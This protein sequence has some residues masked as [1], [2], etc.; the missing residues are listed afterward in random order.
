MCDPQLR[1][2]LDA[3]HGDAER[4]W[5]VDDLAA[6]AAMSRSAFAQRF[7]GV[8]GQSPLGYLAEWRMQ[9][10]YDWLQQGGTVLDVALRCGYRTEPAF[11]R[12]FK[13]HTGLTPGSVRRAARIQARTG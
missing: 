3:M 2:A 5:T 6:V 1:R 11:H 12:A 10:A 13:R 9:L 4:A 8:V 7:H